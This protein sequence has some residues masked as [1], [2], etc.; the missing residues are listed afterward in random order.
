MRYVSRPVRKIDGMSLVTGKPLYTD[1][2]APKEC[3]IVKALRSPYAYARIKNI[4]VSKAKMVKG[5]ACVLTYKDV[6]KV[7]F[8]N[9]GQTYP[10]MSSYDR[11]IL[12]EYVR[13]VGDEVALVAAA[14]EKAAI[15]A[16]K[17][18]K[19]D[20]EVLTPVLDYKKAKDNP[21]IVHNYEDYHN[22]YDF[23]GQNNK[24]NIVV[25]GMD[26]HGDVEGEF[27][28]SDVIVDHEYENL[29]QEQCMMETFRTYT[30]MDH[31]GRLC[32]VTSTQV[33]FHVRRILSRALQIPQSRIR[34][35]KPRIGGGFGAKQTVVSEFYPAIITLKTGLPA[36]IIYTRKEAFSASNSRHQMCIR[37]KIGA[38]F[39]GTIRAIELDTLSNQ[40]AYGEHGTTTIGLSGHKSLP[41]YN[42]ARAFRFKY[43]GVYTNTM[44]A[45]AFRGYGAT[46]GLF[47]LESAV[48]EL[49]VKLGMDPTRLREKNMVRF[50]EIMPA[51][52]NEKMTSSALDRCIYRGREMIQ[53]DKKYPRTQISDT[54]V[55]AVGMAIAMQGSGIAKVD[56]AG[57][58]IKLN[59]D[60]FYTLKIG[61]TDMGTGCDTILTQIAAEALLADMDQFIVAQVDTDISPFD[62]GSYASAT[63]YVTGMAVYNAACDLKNKIIF[64]GA[65]MLDPEKYTVPLEK[66]NPKKFFFDGANVTEVSSGKSVSIHDIAIHCA[67]NYT[68]TYLNGSGFYSSPTSPPPLMAG[69]VEI[70]LD[71]ETGKYEI[72]D[73]V[74]VVDCG[75][76]INTSLARVQTEGGIAQGIGLAMYE[77]VKYSD[78]GKMMTNSFM[79]YKIPSRVDVGKIR[80][81]F[82]SSYE[83][84]GPYGAKSIGEIVVNTPSPAI[85]DALRNA[86]GI[87][88]R[89]LPITPE[90]VLAAI[91]EAKDNG[92][93]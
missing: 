70:E 14:N 52:Y 33:P 20:Y 72:L 24:R 25:E 60:G 82:E 61:A 32:V 49:A 93:G 22:N 27:S 50:G 59:D 62:S 8:T 78:K 4:D 87:N 76:V 42:Q 85:A 79:Q 68:G 36:K 29:A 16:L 75:T 81:A 41:L 1:D 92:E 19:V 7:R 47:A 90:K 53:W 89:S 67:G 10:E 63:T 34:V 38:D 86:A 5:V 39:D 57:A 35:I 48:N 58:E 37:V 40:G 56:T 21:V 11:L 2:L 30:Y 9:A 55:R 28:R 73:Y 15:Q 43:T 18:I 64:A 46:Q 71:K 17:L 6:P 91:E 13:Y 44:P 23:Q 66:F 45:G 69:F 54:K 83:P 84:S 12:D 26:E 31:N 77:D 88:M 65:K 74:G 51:Y 80:V 3:L